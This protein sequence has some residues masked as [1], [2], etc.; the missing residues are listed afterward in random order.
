MRCLFNFSFFPY[1]SPRREFLVTQQMDIVIVLIEKYLIKSPLDSKEL[2]PVNP[3]GNQSWIFIGRTDAEAE[4]PVL[5]PP[6][7]RSRII[8]K[9]PDFNKDWRE[10]DGRG[11][12]S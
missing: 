10:R 11:W 3:K 2:K 7:A 5:R 9:D 8:G 6:D 1:F 12:D 4:A